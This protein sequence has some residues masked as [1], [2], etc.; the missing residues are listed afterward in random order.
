MNNEAPRVLVLGA[1]GYVGSHLVPRLIERGYRVRASARHRDVLESR[2]W[3]CELIRPMDQRGG[4]HSLRCTV[5][6]RCAYLV[7]TSSIRSPW[8]PDLS[9]AVIAVTLEGG[10]AAHHSGRAM[11]PLAPLNGPLLVGAFMAA[12]WLQRSGSHRSL[13]HAV[14]GETGSRHRARPLPGA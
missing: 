1:S 8:P 7:V 11:E 4:Q 9:V 3:D 2:G 6:P 12:R 10:P 5:R 14:G 13:D